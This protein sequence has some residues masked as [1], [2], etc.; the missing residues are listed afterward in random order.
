MSLKI[1]I[2]GLPNVGKSTIFNALT[3]KKVD[4]SNYPFCTIEPNVGIIEVPDERLTKLA[5]LVPSAQIMPAVIEI[6]DV[7]GLIKGA[8]QGEGLGNQFLSHLFPMDALMFLIRCF[9][10]KEISSLVD[11]PQEQLDI[12][13]D[14]LLKK[15]EQLAERAK[16]EKKDPPPKLSE[17]T[18]LIVCNIH[19][20]KENSEFQVCQ[21]KID[22]KLEL[23]LSEMTED[24]AKEL[25]ISS[26]LPHLI[27]AA[28]ATLNLITFY[29]IK[30][31]KELRAWPIKNGFPAPKA[32]GIVHTD[33]E[34]KFIRAEIVN[35]QNLLEAG[36]WQNAK[37]KGLIKT[38]GKEYVVKDGDVIEFRI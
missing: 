28:Y 20:G 6:V 33:F 34:E 29:T 3:R 37:E 11:N 2:I 14:E 13:K 19:S 15:D 9:R 7:A 35:W 31:G 22:S 1:G 27:K 4:I 18:A 21:I 32:A 38:E 30:G 12:L 23:E 36:S 10:D 16:E 25:N 17:K 8:H 24:E 5:K 26:D